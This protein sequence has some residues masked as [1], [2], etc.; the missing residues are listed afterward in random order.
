MKYSFFLTTILLLSLTIV[1]STSVLAQKD[2]KY[3]IRARKLFDKKKYD[4][5]LEAYKKSF[6]INPNWKAA[7]GIG[8]D[9]LRV[10]NPTEA[11]VYF[12]K[13]LQL[14]EDEPLIWYSLGYSFG[15]LNEN[16]EAIPALQKAVALKPDYTDA[17]YNLGSVLFK[18]GRYKEA[19][20]AYKTTVNLN[21][22]DG[23]AYAFLGLAYSNT[24]N[25]DKAVESFRKA[26]K[27]A[28]NNDGY[29]QHLT[30][31]ETKLKEQGQREP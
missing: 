26:V 5:A 14:K 30:R 27:I 20:E 15:K 2:D 6:Q 1:F 8:S 16:D 21:P 28:P 23:E 29:R 18:S 7:Y 19:V 13:A 11:I 31:L 24:N 9:Y 10:E 22:K 25:F 12:R 17:W 3:L 4:E